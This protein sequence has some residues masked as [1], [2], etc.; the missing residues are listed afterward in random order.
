MYQKIYVEGRL[1]KCKVE[2]I[3]YESL[4]GYYRVYLLYN[5][6][7]YLVRVRKGLEEERDELL[8]K[9]IFIQNIKIV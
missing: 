8:D 5:F 4:T 3:E 7:E 9:W 6:K 2:R 1:Q